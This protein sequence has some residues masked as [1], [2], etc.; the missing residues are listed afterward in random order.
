MVNKNPKVALIYMPFGAFHSPAI[1]IALL[2][3]ELA[4]QGAECETYYFNLTLA[5]ELGVTAYHAITEEF[6]VASLLGEW[7]FAP[8]VFGENSD[9]DNAYVHDVLWEKFPEQFPPTTVVALLRIRSR[10][11]TFLRE[12]AE[13]VDWSQY[14][15]VGFSVVS[16]QTCASLALARLIKAQFPNVRIIFGGANCTGEMGVALCRVFPFIDFV[17]TGE[18]DVAFPRLVQRVAQ[19]DAAPSVPGIFSRSNIFG[20]SDDNLPQISNLDVLPYPEYADYFSQL[21][22]LSTPPG[23]QPWTPIETSRGCWWGQVS[24]CTFCGFNRAGL[25]FRS[26]S[27]DRVINELV[28]LKEKYGCQ[29]RFEDNIFDYHYF[30]TL[31]PALVA[32]DLNLSLFGEVKANLKRE[33]I[34]LL[35]QAGF[36]RIHAG[37]ESLNDGGLKLIR[38]GTTQIQNIQ[39]L[40][41][42]KQYGVTV[43]WNFLY[44]FP[45]E[46]PAEYAATLSLIPLLLHLD[47]PAFWQHIRFERFS[48]YHEEPLAYGIT[49]LAP[50][51]AYQCIYHSLSENDLNQIAY[52]F[53][54]EYPDPSAAYERELAAAVCEWQSRTDAVLDVFPS[55]QS[56]HIVGTRTRG[57]KQEYQFYGLAAEIYLQCDTA[58][59]VRTLVEHNQA[60]EAEV[61]PILHQFVELGLMLRSDKQYLSLAVVRDERPAGLSRGRGC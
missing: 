53:D 51:R 56:I 17:C 37:I 27:P 26:K 55:A 41:W 14:D 24:R 39:T 21:K 3:S 6:P 44:G 13:C 59:N 10:L 61:M 35:A 22:I 47:A 52:I 9:A 8:A 50:A 25:D 12:C 43:G 57:E 46:D 34:A 30:H 5:N 33:Q 48:A 31:L 19:G 15:W 18:G 23:F 7:L 38:K 32:R 16:H 11:S 2:K 20:Y 28:Y 58:Q 54:A 40:K 60:T 45:C 42:G 49:S 1:G 4:R 29:I 36:E